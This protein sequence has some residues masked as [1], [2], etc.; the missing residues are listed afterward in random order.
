MLIMAVSLRKQKLL[1]TAF[2]PHHDPRVPDGQVASRQRAIKDSEVFPPEQTQ[3]GSV[4][5]EQMSPAPINK[6]VRPS[7][8]MA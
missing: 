3:E 8:L 2:D 4:R 6:S 5:R 7:P 1:L